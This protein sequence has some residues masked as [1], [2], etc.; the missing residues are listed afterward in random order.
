MDHEVDLGGNE[1]EHLE[2][3]YIYIVTIIAICL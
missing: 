1:G 3:S 2:D